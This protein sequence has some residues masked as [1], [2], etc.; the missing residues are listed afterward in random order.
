M[1]AA[2]PV[3][4]ANSTTTSPAKPLPLSDS[5]SQGVVGDGTLA[6]KGKNNKGVGKAA[7]KRISGMARLQ[8]TNSEKKKVAGGDLPFECMSF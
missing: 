1:S 3:T 5:S 8:A 2:Q 7:A 6:V 4:P